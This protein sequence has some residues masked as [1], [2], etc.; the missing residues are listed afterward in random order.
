MEKHYF[1][2]AKAMRIVKALTLIG[3]DAK[4]DTSAGLSAIRIISNNSD[5]TV[6]TNQEAIDCYFDD[7]IEAS[8][9]YITIS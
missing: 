9:R 6:F 4:Y 2:K 5:E 7:L 1:T 8:D 3:I